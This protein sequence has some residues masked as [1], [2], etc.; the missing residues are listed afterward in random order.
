[1]TNISNM[2][3]FPI[4]VLVFTLYQNI[5]KNREIYEII[6]KNFINQ[7]LTTLINS[8]IFLKSIPT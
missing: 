2:V 5:D 7:D 8:L 6:F 3:S 4:S 1:M